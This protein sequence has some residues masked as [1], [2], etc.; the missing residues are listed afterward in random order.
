M[1]YDPLRAPPAAEW[2][3][4]GELDRIDLV[5]DFHKKARIKLPNARAHSILHAIVEN[6]IALSTPAVLEAME[7][8]KAGGLD[9]HGAIHAVGTVLLELLRELMNNPKAHP[10]QQTNEMYASALSHLTV[11]WWLEN[12]GPEK[13]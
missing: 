3:E 1:K 6:Q 7:R 10:P 5:A 11:S 2:L 4:I 8:L 13:K 12:Y 9:R